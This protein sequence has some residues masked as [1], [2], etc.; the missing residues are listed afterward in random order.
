MNKRWLGVCCALWVVGACTA[1]PVGEP[2]LELKVIRSGA[3]NEPVIIK[4]TATAADGTVGKGIIN[5][6]TPAGAFQTDDVAIDGFGTANAELVCDPVSNAACLQPYVIDARWNVK[7]VVARASIK[8]TP[9]ALTASSGGDGGAGSEFFGTAKVLLFGDLNESSCE[10]GAL[11][12]PRRPSVVA[13]SFNC[14]VHD[15]KYVNGQVY[16]ITF[17]DSQLFRFRADSWDRDMNGSRYPSPDKVG[18][19]VISTCAPVDR[20]WVSPEGR[21]LYS[22]RGDLYQAGV[23]LRAD[24]IGI[25]AYGNNG[26]ILTEDGI[27]TS[28]GVT[29]PFSPPLTFQHI[30]PSLALADG[31]LATKDNSDRTNCAL[32]HVALDGTVTQRGSYGVACDPQSRLDAQGSLTFFSISPA[33]QFIDEIMEVPP[34]G[35][36]VVIYSEANATAADWSKFPPRVYN[37]IHVSELVGAN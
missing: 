2:T 35:T 25:M 27:V 30:D 24:D 13:V 5:F 34:D 15:F 10:A 29:R 19:E 17:G 36:P 18:D 12:D 8:I 9:N 32:Y 6:S 23:T 21:V 1:G 37:K 14:N 28:D 4:A 7:G 11:S 31:F 22:C 16:Y 33:N 3:P 20:Y 26:T